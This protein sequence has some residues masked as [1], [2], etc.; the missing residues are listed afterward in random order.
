MLAASEHFHFY[1]SKTI[2]TQAVH[3]TPAQLSLELELR[4]FPAQSDDCYLNIFMQYPFI[5]FI[6]FY[7][8]VYDTLYIV[9][10]TLCQFLTH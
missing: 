7:I 1:T 2:A 3:L 8:Y 4:A 10:C 6:S 5:S 9:I